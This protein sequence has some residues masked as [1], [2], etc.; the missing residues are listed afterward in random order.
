M[1]ETFKEDIDTEMQR[2]QEFARIL[3]SDVI[4]SSST[5]GHTHLS[6]TNLG[7]LDVQGTQIIDVNDVALASAATRVGNLDDALSGALGGTK[8]LTGSAVFSGKQDINTMATEVLQGEDLKSIKAA[9]NARQGKTLQGAQKTTASF[10]ARASSTLGSCP[11]L[12]NP[13]AACT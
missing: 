5:S 13:T 2:R 3:E 6:H 7:G 1:K 8:K 11:I 9:L 4:D 12:V 10:R